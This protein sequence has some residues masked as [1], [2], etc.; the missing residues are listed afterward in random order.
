MSC[1][2]QRKSVCRSPCVWVVGK[3]CRSPPSNALP[4]FYPGASEK[5]DRAITILHLS[6]LTNRLLKTQEH[7]S[8]YIEKSRNKAILNKWKG[9]L[10]SDSKKYGVITNADNAW[11]GFEHAIKTWYI[12]QVQFIIGS[13]ANTKSFGRVHRFVEESERNLMQS[14]LVMYG[15]L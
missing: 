4:T 9:V 3:G 12:D 7:L 8:E 5:A 11:E 14:F 2:K 13:P 10:I 1:S 6:V 15:H